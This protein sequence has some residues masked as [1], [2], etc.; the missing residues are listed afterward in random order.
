MTPKQAE[1]GISALKYANGGTV[2]RNPSVDE[3]RYELMM[4]SK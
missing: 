4:R 2:Q 1:E 3:M